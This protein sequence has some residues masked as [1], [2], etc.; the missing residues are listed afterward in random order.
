MVIYVL[1]DGETWSGAPCVAVEVDEKQLSRIEGG[2]KV[3]NVI[4][5]WD[6]EK[7]ASS[8]AEFVYS[9]LSDDE[10]ISTESFDKL[11]AMLHDLQAHDLTRVLMQNCQTADDRFFL[12]QRF[13]KQE[14][15]NGV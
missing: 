15:T 4:P 9:I 2:D 12:P 14:K 10:G 1:E 7:T 8:T 3:R 13:F 5:D 11:L 6:Q